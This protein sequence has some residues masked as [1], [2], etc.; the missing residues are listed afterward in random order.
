MLQQGSCNILELVQSLQSNNL[1][2]S[3]ILKIPRNILP[4]VPLWDCQLQLLLLYSQAQQEHTPACSCLGLCSR[5]PGN[6]PKMD[7]GQLRKG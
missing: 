2:H 3:Q 7:H 5:F 4:H 6:A 1:L